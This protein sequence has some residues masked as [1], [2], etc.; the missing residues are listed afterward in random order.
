[1]NYCDTSF[2]ASLYI[3]D[4]NT[5]FALHAAKELT[6]P[7]DFSII[8]EFELKNA[9]RLAV[10]REQI[11]PRRAAEALSDIA[12]DQ[13]NGFLAQARS[14]L[15]D[16]LSKAE[17]ISADHTP[18][19]GARALDILHIAYAIVGERASFYTF[20]KRQAKLAQALALNVLPNPS[21]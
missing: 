20:D 13:R 17:I 7:V 4:A 15:V 3:T 11:Q 5:P 21:P 18:K 14:N 8:C 16:A 9:I 1:M 6:E 19:H 12:A 2:L 10:F